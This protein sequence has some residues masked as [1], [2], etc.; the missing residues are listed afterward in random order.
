MAT[1][2]RM[3]PAS[4][5]SPTAMLTTLAMTRMSTS[6]LANWLTSTANVLRR[7]SPPKALGPFWRSRLA[8]SAEVKPAVEPEGES[9]AA[10][11]A[12]GD[13]EGAGAVGAESGADFWGV[14]GDFGGVGGDASCAAEALPVRAGFF[15]IFRMVSRSRPASVLANPA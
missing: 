7:P 2:A 15:A 5:R 12:A 1:I 6:G 3:I 9:A 11:G 10:V 4:T 13:P 14:G 8:A